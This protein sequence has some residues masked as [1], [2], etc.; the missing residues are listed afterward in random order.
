MDTRGFI[1]EWD[2]ESAARRSPDVTRFAVETA[3]H[4]YRGECPYTVDPAVTDKPGRPWFGMGAAVTL[5]P[6]PDGWL[7]YEVIATGDNVGTP[8]V[9]AGERVRV[10]RRAD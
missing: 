8:A 7:I 9:R 5:S 4:W 6:D 1:A 2:F 10:I 3:G